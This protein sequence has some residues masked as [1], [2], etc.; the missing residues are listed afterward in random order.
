MFACPF[1]VSDDAMQMDV[2]KTLYLFYTTKKMPYVTARV[3]TIAFRWHNIA[4]SLLILLVT[5]YKNPW[6]TR[7]CTGRSVADPDQAFGEGSQIRGRQNLFTCLKY[8]SLSAIMAGYHT[9]VVT[10]SR[11]RK[12]LFFSRI[13][14]SFRQTDRQF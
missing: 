6:P 3:A 14:R 8:P 2:H 12:W 5:Q 9:K 7:D 1:Q 10:F 4:S 13:V 11:P